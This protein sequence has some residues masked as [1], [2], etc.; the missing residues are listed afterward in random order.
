MCFGHRPLFFKVHFINV[1]V[2]GPD[3]KAQAYDANRESKFERSGLSCH[4]LGT[5]C[6][7]HQQQ[8][9]WTNVTKQCPER[10]VHLSATVHLRLL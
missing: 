9:D 3:N 6:H 2:P 8:R 4:S 1:S 7:P 5:W 10:K